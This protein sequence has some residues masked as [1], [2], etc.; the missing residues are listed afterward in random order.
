M[1]LQLSQST[2]TCFCSHTQSPSLPLTRTHLHSQ[3]HTYTF[4]HTP[5]RTHIHI[6]THTHVHSQT[7]THALTSTPTHTLVPQAMSHF[8]T[9]KNRPP[10]IWMD[11]S[12]F[13]N[14]TFIKRLFWKR[15]S[16]FSFLVPCNLF[17]QKHLNA[18][19]SQ[20]WKRRALSEA[21]AQLLWWTDVL[22]GHC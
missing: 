19:F 16:Y 17:S 20:S 10:L 9:C 4:K 15:K 1:H 21:V 11:D 12:S 5:I 6:H 8:V 18:L 7:P 2:L 13:S 14:L 22:W 3:L